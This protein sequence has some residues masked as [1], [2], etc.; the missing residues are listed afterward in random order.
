MSTELHVTDGERDG[1][2]G[3]SGP[4]DCGEGA[5]HYA[6]AD[7]PAR[8]HATETGD[9]RPRAYPI[10]PLPDDDRR[11]TFGLRLDVA[12]VLEAHGYPPLVTGIDHVDLQQSLFRFL[13]SDRNGG[14]A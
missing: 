5:V 13:Y 6:D 12:E 14:A 1:D 10:R 9:G 8:R 4:C 11:F 2:E 7:C 3:L